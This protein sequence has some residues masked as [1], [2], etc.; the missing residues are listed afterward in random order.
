ITEMTQFQR[1]TEFELSGV[2]KLLAIRR[3][4]VLGDDGVLFDDFIRSAIELMM[5]AVN[6]HTLIVGQRTWGRLQKDIK[7]LLL[8]SQ[9][10]KT[11]LEIVDQTR[12][13]HLE[14]RAGEVRI[15]ALD[16]EIDTVFPSSIWT[17]EASLDLV[18]ASRSLRDPI[19][20]LRSYADTNP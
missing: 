12:E 5:S 3:V 10:R 2:A 16:C 7:S 15:T 6:V 18:L 13:Y 17:S 14:G 19:H 4:V 1:P 11:F 8:A 20:P 9:R